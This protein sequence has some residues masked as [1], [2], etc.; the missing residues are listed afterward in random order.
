MNAATGN[1]WD[2]AAGW[3]LVPGGSRQNRE[4]T[5]G[6]HRPTSPELHVQLHLVFFSCTICGLQFNGI[7]LFIPSRKISRTFLENSSF[8]EGIS[9]HPVFGKRASKT[10]E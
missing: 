9:T 1:T 7:L 5:P 2:P 8:T 6:K 3:S 10:S 4:L